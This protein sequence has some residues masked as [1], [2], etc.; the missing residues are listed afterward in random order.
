[1]ISPLLIGVFF[2]LLILGIPVAFSLGIATLFAISLTDIPI[3]IVFQR[4]FAGINSFV[5]ICIPFFIL[6]GNIMEKGGIT[7][8]IVNFSNLIIGRIKGGL[9]AVNVLA[10]MF[11][12]GISGSAVADTSSIGAMLIPMMNEEGY[13]RSFSVAITCTSSTIGLIIPPSNSMILYSFVAGGVSVA[14]L[15]AAG[16]IPGILVGLGLII[17]GYIIS[18]KRN[19][20]SH[21]LPSFKEAIK[22]IREAL[23]SL[24][25]VVIIVGGILGGVFTATE[26]A[27]FGAM[28]AFIITF[29]IY[30]ELNLRDL[31]EIFLKTVYTTIIVMFL[32]ATSTA[33]AYILAIE[34]IP[35]LVAGFLLSITTNKYILLFIINIILLIVGMFM[36]MSPAI[37]I[38]TPLLLPIATD[39]GLSPIHFG[40][41]MLVN[42][43]VGL[44]T[45]PVG[46]V[47][48]VGLGIANIKMTQIIKPLLL[49]LIPMII[50]LLLVTYIEPIT[51][52]IPNI[53][54]GK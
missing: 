20:P 6:M 29:F 34:E 33:F 31:P 45:P 51:M 48:F 9:A 23:L 5:L 25:L 22:I 3:I 2:L 53:V 8:R 17:V 18:V 12:G 40:I 19:Y 32:I 46:T 28:Y 37:L 36:D 26:A 15:F 41:I 50:V 27:V 14:K 47:L 44:C 11:F 24:F 42:L 13:D 54:F 21:T 43:C 4:M 1:M 49:F 39:L 16:I 7:R 52:F 38:F 10:S 30:K 35:R